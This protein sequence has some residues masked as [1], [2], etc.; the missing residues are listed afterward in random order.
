[1]AVDND[2]INQYDKDIN[3]L[4]S[5]DKKTLYASQ[6][7]E[8]FQHEQSSVA[9]FA[10]NVNDI[11]KQLDQDMSPSIEMFATHDPY[12]DPN[13]FSDR[14]EAFGD[15]YAQYGFSPYRNN[16]ALYNMVA[17]NG[18]MW[19]R[20]FKAFRELTC[21][22]IKQNYTWDTER[23]KE[24]ATE[25]NYW[26]SIGMSTREGTNAFLQNLLVT[27]GSTAAVVAEM[28]AEEIVASVVLGLLTEGSGA[29]VEGA[30][31]VARIT[32]FINKCSTAFKNFN[33]FS[34]AMTNITA[35][36]GWRTVGEFLAP[37]TF[38]HITTGFRT[39]KKA[40]NAGNMVQTVGGV[41]ECLYGVYSG[42]RAWKLTDSE[43]R[44]ESNLAAEEFVM[45]RLHD[46]Y[47]YTEEEVTMLKEAAK[48]VANETYWKNMFA[49]YASNLVI[50]NSLLSPVI[51]KTI[52]KPFT[53]MGSRIS[54]NLPHAMPSQKYKFFEKLSPS[55]QF[56]VG[57]KFLSRSE[58]P[59]R[60]WPVLGGRMLLGGLKYFAAG[61]V[62]GLQENVQDIISQSAKTY[63]NSLYEDKKYQE[64]LGASY[65]LDWFNG[66]TRSRFFTA[67]S[68]AI[69]SQFSKQG[70]D[71]FLT[72]TLMGGPT[73][74][75][76]FGARKFGVGA[77]R[78]LDKRKL[79]RAEK[80][81]GK[82]S[83]E[84]Q[85]LKKQFEYK[86]DIN[87][88]QTNELQKM[89]E[90]VFNDPKKF[91]NKNLEM[92]AN[93]DALNSDISK[94][95]KSYDEAIAN[96]KTEK[97]KADI[98]EKKAAALESARRR[99]W[100]IVFRTMSANGTMDMVINEL[101]GLEN[102][103]DEV[104]QAFYGDPT[105]TK[106]DIKYCIEVAKETAKI[107]D[108]YMKE[109]DDPSDVKR[110]FKK[111]GVKNYDELASKYD[112]DSDAMKEYY[113]EILKSVAY[114]SIVDDIMFYSQEFSMA[115]DNK[116]SIAKKINE[117]ILSIHEKRDG[118]VY[119]DE[120]E[121]EYYIT[122]RD[123]TEKQQR[124]KS[125]TPI[126]G[127]LSNG[128]TD[129]DLTSMMT[130]NGIDDVIKSLN[131]L[132]VSQKSQLESMENT[133]SEYNTLKADI[134]HTEKRIKGLKI[135]KKYL[136]NKNTL[137]EKEQ[138]ELE[139]AIYTNVYYN[140]LVDEFLSYYEA[141]KTQQR[142]YDVINS[143][144]N[145][146]SRQALLQ[147]R[148]IMLFDLFN[149]RYDIIADSLAAYTENTAIND[150]INQ[151]YQMG[152]AIDKSSIEALQGH[153]GNFK[154]YKIVDGAFNKIEGTD[155]SNARFEKAKTYNPDE[156]FKMSF[157]V[158]IHPLSKEY[159]DVLNKIIEIMKANPQS[160][161]VTERLIN[162]ANNKR[163]NVSVGNNIE[164]KDVND[165]N[166]EDEKTIEQIE[167]KYLDNNAPDKLFTFIDDVQFDLNDLL[168]KIKLSENNKTF[169]E[170]IKALQVFNKSLGIKV[171]FGT[172]DDT[173][174]M[175]K[176]KTLVIDPRY[177]DSRYKSNNVGM[178][179]A[180]GLITANLGMVIATYSMTNRGNKNLKEFTNAFSFGDD[181]IRNMANF[182]VGVNTGIKA[183]DVNINKNNL[184]TNVN[185]TGFIRESLDLLLNQL[186]LAKDSE[187]Y[188]AIMNTIGT[189]G[190]FSS[191]GTRE[192]A[193]KQGN[194]SPRR[195]SDS[196]MVIKNN[197]ADIDV[198][199]IDLDFSQLSPKQKLLVLLNK[200][201]ANV[202][203]WL[204][205]HENDNDYKD[206]LG[207]IAQREKT[208]KD[209]FDKG[210]SSNEY[211]EVRESLNIGKVTQSYHINYVY[212][213]LGI[214]QTD[215]DEIN[216]MKIDSVT[217]DEDT[218]TKPTTFNQATTFEQAV[219]NY[220]K[221]LNVEFHP[222]NHIYTVD[223]IQTD[224]SATGIISKILGEEDN[225]D[226]DNKKGTIKGLI[227]DAALRAYYKTGNV[228][229]A[230]NEIDDILNLTDKD[231]NRLVDELTDSQKDQMMKSLQDI[232]EKS[233]K[234]L[235]DKLGWKEEDIELTTTESPFVVHVSLDAD[236]DG[237]KIKH[238]YSVGMTTDMVAVNKKTGKSVVID[239]KTI[240][241]GKGVPKDKYNLQ[242]LLY[243][244]GID[245][246]VE[247][248]DKLDKV[249]DRLLIKVVA[250]NQINE[251]TY[252][253][254][255]IEVI[256][257][258]EY[259]N[260][261]AVVSVGTDKQ[262]K[263]TNLVVNKITKE[264]QEAPTKNDDQI[265]EEF[266]ERYSSEKYPTNQSIKE[267]FDE[268]IGNGS[269]ISQERLKE[270]V[271]KFLNDNGK[272]NVESVKRNDGNYLYLNDKN[273]FVV[274][275]YEQ[276]FLKIDGELIHNGTD[277]YKRVISNLI[278]IAYQNLVNEVFGIINPPAQTNGTSS[279]ITDILNET[280]IGN[281]SVDELLKALKDLCK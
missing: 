187:L 236:I 57:N 25:Y 128:I 67:D 99:T 58:L 5:L 62:E 114:K 153:G 44:L 28:V 73:A 279:T 68:N 246:I 7:P 6:H 262:L 56:R 12:G 147:A 173:E 31:G 251:K 127:S 274:A 185:Q 65:N 209:A 181:A 89:Y 60:G 228:N 215:I 106:E 63:Y 23:S 223:G 221:G 233:K 160:G 264:K 280:T 131:I 64:I 189:Y 266:G 32:Q 66:F 144:I 142:L 259:G 111:Y 97:E 204:K 126:Y 91:F 243:E 102:E 35:K 277:E 124:K 261:D 239:F 169:K 77:R 145:P 275:T 202:K 174:F 164:V 141:Y 265:V 159:H 213:F 150:I 276:G 78:L 268:I 80:K 269:D 273:V 4:N 117:L 93:L 155:S 281:E 170:L 154:L 29:V 14:Y 3:N 112:E 258:K 234:L 256:D 86:Y 224:T 252:S 161:I 46:D 231:G 143:L 129:A 76:S 70:W 212:G 260:N 245:A 36:S 120:K 140:S 59:Y 158:V 48:A 41:L 253:D 88:V 54:R 270:L 139:E 24:L 190:A 227:L 96:A 16:E 171:V 55:R 242:T 45:S 162:I 136:S 230:S 220:S 116:E 241:P 113:N 254:N 156:A 87:D 84:Y 49:I 247:G 188:D 39:I 133:D 13:M 146:Q 15:L 195:T 237:Q 214:T 152:Y 1:M 98:V 18:D 27:Y 53:K 165:K 207:Q 177:W 52:L 229:D 193:R 250:T 110:I 148:T 206:A 40:Q 101:E 115:Q 130:A 38:S 244:K 33:R 248:N 94:I 83:T 208:W 50:F 240:S 263:I 166:I 271:L 90:A 198:A 211:T 34:R 125:A 119:F 108:A 194:A 74:A 180:L 105:I 95:T 9:T 92:M 69:A 135:I 82:S 19:G 163:K 132:L 30:K 184:T 157:D 137:T 192:E 232:A 149:K 196:G 2:K 61:S 178:S 37:G 238:E 22:A 75:F 278:G 205:K 175:F 118:Y 267:L 183:E 8:E 51:G 85:A 104:L 100:G 235:F 11:Y 176:G 210:E 218:E 72:G 203:S 121:N 191:T 43:A 20:A 219:S 134:E 179:F 123:L 182:L 217:E 226:D 216:N 71:T 81:Y 42:A 201:S 255:N 17:T 186:G 199:S 26:N 79:K 172:L 168:A 109:Y 249:T 138:K 103:S 272:V 197:N 107:Y 200:N 222:E 151:L 122:G 257:F 10:E 167:H 21:I 47:E 225:N